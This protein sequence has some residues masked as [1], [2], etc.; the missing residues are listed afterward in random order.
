MLAMPSSAQVIPVSGVH[1]SV[2]VPEAAS[3]ELISRE[4]VPG[5]R[6]NVAVQSLDALYD[7]A[8]EI[9]ESAG[10]LALGA[11]APL[12]ERRSL[13]SV[14][15][16]ESRA[17]DL[18]LPALLHRTYAESRP[19]RGRAATEPEP[20]LVTVTVSGRTASGQPAFSSAS[21]ALETLRPGRFTVTPLSDYLARSQDTPA[22]LRTVLPA[23]LP[24]PRNAASPGVSVS[25]SRRANLVMDAEGRIREEPVE[26]IRPG[27]K[28]FAP[29]VPMSSATASVVTT[30][31]SGTI[32][33]VDYTGT[34]VPL[35]YAQVAVFED[36]GSS[37]YAAWN[38]I[39]LT[40]ANGYFTTTVSQ[41]E[42]DGQLELFLEV[43][44]ENSLVRMGNGYGWDGNCHS[45]NNY[46]GLGSETNKYRWTGSVQSGVTSG[47]LSMSYAITDA[48]KGGAYVFHKLMDAALLPNSAFSPGQ[49][50]AVW[51]LN[52][53]VAASLY[54]YGN[55]LIFGAIHGQ[56]RSED[57]HY[58]EYGHFTMYRRNSYKASGVG[59]SHYLNQLIAPAF[60]WS[61]G[62][63][64][65]F[66]QH[67]LPD[68]YYD[69]ANFYG[70]RLPVE[71]YDEMDAYY[72]DNTSTGHNEF[73]VAGAVNDFYDF[74]EPGGGDDPAERIQSFFEATEIIR[75]NNI[76][77]IYDF[78][79][80]LLASGYL[81]QTEKNHASRVM[82]TN[83]FSTTVLPT[84]NPLSAS[85]SGPYNLTYGTSGTW[86]ANVSGGE[87]APSYA[88][89]WL[90]NPP[91]GG[92]L[93]P[94]YGVWSYGG[95][96]QSYTRTILNNAET[97][98]LRVTVTKGTQSVTAYH[99]VYA[100]GSE[101]MYSQGVVEAG[102]VPEAFA[103]GA[104]QPNPARHSARVV[105]E[106][107]EAASVQVRV[108]DLLGREVARPLDGTRA[109]GRYAVHLSAEALPAGLYF[110]RM[111]A[112]AFSA[113]QRFAVSH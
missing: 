56:Q 19:M 39:L 74:G 21:Y 69:A 73:W 106:I 88:S 54:N 36:D 13:G 29:E 99:T 96:G 79:N 2:N 32:T 104:V 75:L 25:V 12:H 62:W 40:D 63:A 67:V 46:C 112:G 49:V 85:I 26:S 95:S 66:A 5:G 92:D 42:P 18:P 93:G 90:I 34:L 70:E 24:T 50:K 15:Q 78:Y 71:R 20:V 108:F 11:S 9:K 30:T 61:E 87:G 48:R 82:N 97:M 17:L 8:V 77:S 80:A 84:V 14:R 33:Y 16:N 103:L 107:P 51:G 3:I 47:S 65:G 86:T 59:G 10:A 57:V 81:T 55:H 31:V 7:V 100:G 45:G 91:G 27:G 4:A 6:L 89:E 83:G 64:T 52:T 43:T 58:H 28:G 22:P 109:A 68:G 41:D 110:V 102:G 23:Q 38:N 113:T 98:N 105:V 53:D 44:S 37:A 94:T 76:A 101:P 72:T 35:P 111:E 1:C 60:A